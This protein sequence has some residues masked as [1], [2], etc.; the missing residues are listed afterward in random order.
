MEHIPPILSDSRLAF[1]AEFITACL[2]DPSANDPPVGAVVVDDAIPAHFE[3]A[4]AEVAGEGAA[5][6]YQAC[7]V[8]ASVGSAAFRHGSGGGADDRETVTA[9]RGC[10]HP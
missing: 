3:I 6:P 7:V 1:R 5:G 8:E 9:V 10:F 2:L 4:L